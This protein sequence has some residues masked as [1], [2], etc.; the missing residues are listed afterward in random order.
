MNSYHSGEQVREESL[1]V[2]EQRALALDAP[3][4][5]EERQAQDL[6]VREPLYGLVAVGLGVE[7]RENRRRR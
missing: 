6:A 1:G 5:L 2:T 4:L 7:M 3:E